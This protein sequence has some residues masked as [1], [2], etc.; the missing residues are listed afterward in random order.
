MATSTQPSSLFFRIPLEIREQ[1]YHHVFL[2]S[3]C[4]HAAFPT[5]PRSSTA[6]QPHLNDITL[7]YR[8]PDPNCREQRYAS[9]Y[10]HLQIDWIMSCKA[11]FSE[12]LEQFTR[13]AEWVVC[14]IEGVICR[15]CKHCSSEGR[16][17][18][19]IKRHWTT[20]IPVN[21]ARIRKME[22]NVDNLTN[23]ETPKRYEH[24]DEYDGIDTTE[25]LKALS[26]VMR[27]AHMQ[28]DTLRFVGN[29]YQLRGTGKRK[30]KPS[31]WT[32]GSEQTINIMQQLIS[33]FDGIKVDRWELGIVDMPRWTCWVLFEWVDSEGLRIIRNEGRQKATDP[34][35]EED[36]LNLLPPG[37]VLKIPTCGDEDC[38]DCNPL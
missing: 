1:I 5:Q 4:M 14:G 3:R 25:Q 23:F 2:Y 28:L 34:R 24:W 16:R 12:A 35:P 17:T 15:S 9:G 6:S 32:S 33:F 36:L 29:S 27:A 19:A 7:R 18:S 26:E 31:I 10:E 37:W 22:V 30:T 8:L 13:N 20:R 38:D 11:I 21:S